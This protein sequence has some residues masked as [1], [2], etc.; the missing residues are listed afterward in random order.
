[1]ELTPKYT[2]PVTHQ[3]RQATSSKRIRYTIEENLKEN[4][5]VGKLYADWKLKQKPAVVKSFEGI[6]HD[7]YTPKLFDIRLAEIRED[8]GQRNPLT[9]R[10]RVRKILGIAQEFDPMLFKPIDV[11]YIVEEDIFIIRNGGGSSTAAY[12][13]GIYMVPASVR[14]VRD[15][16]ECRR[17]FSSQDRFNAAI[18][19]YDK[20]LQQLLDNKHARHKVACDTWSLANSSKFSLDHLNKSAETPLIEGIS[21][22]QRVIRTVGG[23]PKTVKAGKREAPNVTTAVDLIKDTFI[24]VEEIPVSVLEAITAFIHVS[25]NRIPKGAEGY[26]RL[27]EF[28]CLIRDTDDDLGVLSNWTKSLA[29]DSSNN[30]GAYGA[31]ALMGEWN[32]VFKNR[33]K[34]RKST[35]RYVKWS[36]YEMQVVKTSS[37]KDLQPFARDESLFPSAG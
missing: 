17:L 27:K 16:K 31:A 4:P 29:F 11:D 6:Y 13:N 7:D 1:M 8:W 24:G 28:M 25:K 12:L 14:I 26:K 20:F 22:L 19:S 15:V 36:D 10:G 5:E 32:R 9:E 33:N 34:G 2:S 35:Y 30:Y 37:L 21:M 18:S 23:D 3:Y